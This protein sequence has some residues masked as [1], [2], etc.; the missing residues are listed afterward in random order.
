MRIRQSVESLE[1]EGR[2]NGFSS[3]RSIETPGLR[4]SVV[5]RF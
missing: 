3:R 4:A 1:E 2:R 5:L